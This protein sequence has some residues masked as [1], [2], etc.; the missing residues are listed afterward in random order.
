[1]ILSLGHTARILTIQS[2][3]VDSGKPFDSALWPIGAAIEGWL[4]LMIVIRDSFIKE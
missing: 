2:D 3:L 1:M 4:G